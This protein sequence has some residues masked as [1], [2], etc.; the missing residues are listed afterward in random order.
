MSIE[1]E[2]EIEHVISAGNLAIWPE[3]AGEEMKQGE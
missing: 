2:G 1:E 3:I